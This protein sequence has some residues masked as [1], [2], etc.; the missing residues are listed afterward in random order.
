MVTNAVQRGAVTAVR[1]VSFQ[2]ERG[3]VFVIM[4]L[5]GSGK[6]TLIRCLLR[7]I[8]PTAGTIMADGQDVTAMNIQ[9]LREFRRYRVAMVFQHYGLLPHRTVLENVGFGLKLRGVNKAEREE[10]ALK[11]I[12]SV[13]LAGWEKRYPGDLSGGMQ[14]R[15]GI[16]RALLQDPNILLLDEPFSGLD[17]LIRRELQDELMRLQAEFQTTMLFVTHDLQ[18]ALLLGD[19]MAVM[20]DGTFVQVG[21]PHE[22]VKQPAD[23]YVRRFVQDERRMAQLAN[24]GGRVKQT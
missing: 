11:A 17:P 12:E 7:L 6:S 18:E 10:A 1:D 20:R 16:A 9:Q 21:K 14:Q 4:G 13:G 22:I 15:V 5:S 24:E 2:V 23:D 19:R 3:E 8:E